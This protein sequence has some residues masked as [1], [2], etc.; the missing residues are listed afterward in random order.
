MQTCIEIVTRNSYIFI[1]LKGIGFL[2][3]GRR[4][5]Q[6]I[7]SHG[8]VFMVVN[9]LGSLIM[10]LGKVLISVA[11]AFAAYILLEN[12]ADFQPG[13]ATPVTSSWLPVLLTLFFAYATA[14]GFMQVFDMAVDTMLVCYCVDVDENMQR[15]QGN[16][17]FAVP[18]HIKK[19]KLDAKGR[20]DKAA[21]AEEAAASGA[22]KAPVQ[23]QQQKQAPYQP[24]PS[25]N[26]II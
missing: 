12:M 5:F 11:S 16:S 20:A 7:V 15:H 13:G 24:R 23:Q 9:V 25:V 17:A 1:A 21:A 22:T 4:V 19:N 2:P 6:L 14:S 10:L 3:A 26:E 8:S 18:V